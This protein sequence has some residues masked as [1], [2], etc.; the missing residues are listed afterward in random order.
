MNLF[1]IESQFRN[2]QMNVYN[3]TIQHLE[4]FSELGD[5]TSLQDATSFHVN[6][7]NI[8]LLTMSILADACRS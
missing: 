6:I 5:Y 8:C 2:E 4:A 7:N 3:E 1:I